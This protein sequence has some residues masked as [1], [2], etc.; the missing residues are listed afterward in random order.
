MP[1]PKIFKRFASKSTLRA[2][3]DAAIALDGLLNNEKETP[4]KTLVV[5]AVVPTYPE[6]L[7]EAWAAAHK[8]L[9]EAQGVE[10]FLNRVG[11]STIGALI[12]SLTQKR[13]HRGCAE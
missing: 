11:A 5:A 1:V 13:P 7:T 2:G 8:E 3:P 6:N 4:S 12:G 10:K 9:P